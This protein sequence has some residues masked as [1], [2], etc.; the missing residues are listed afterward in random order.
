MKAKKQ[1]V[2]EAKAHLEFC[3]RMLRAH[4]TLWNHRWESI[5]N[6]F[7]R[8]KDYTSEEQ[9]AVRQPIIDQWLDARRKYHAMEK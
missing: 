7:L 3:A 8:I 9:R 5:P 1:E 2:E 4:E 6:P